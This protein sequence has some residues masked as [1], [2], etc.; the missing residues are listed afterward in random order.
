MHVLAC[1]C[2]LVLCRC[3][4][5]W[6][7]VYMCKCVC[8]FVCMCERGCVYILSKTKHSFTL[9]LGRAIS[10]PWARILSAP[11]SNGKYKYFVSFKWG[12][13]YFCP[14]L[15]QWISITENLNFGPAFHGPK[16]TPQSL[17]FLPTSILQNS[18]LFTL[19]AHIMSLWYYLCFTPGLEYFLLVSVMLV[20][21]TNKSPNEMSVA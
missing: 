18:E 2:M 13:F 15:S 12:V 4:S 11:L 1:V 9:L 21:L 5:G 20:A 8:A 17:S 10:H 3:A 16:W 14:A 6:V 7:C 19:S